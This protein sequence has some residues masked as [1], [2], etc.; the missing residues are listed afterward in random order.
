MDPSNLTSRAGE[1]PSNFHI[2]HLPTTMMISRQ[3]CTTLLNAHKHPTYL[4]VTAPKIP[5]GPTIESPHQAVLVPRSGA[6]FR[7]IK[8]VRRCANGQTTIVLPLPSHGTERDLKAAESVFLGFF[9]RKATLLRWR[10]EDGRLRCSLPECVAD[11]D[12]PVAQVHFR[13]S[14]VTTRT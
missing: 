4:S 2:A 1:R 6:A 11:L 8:I 10:K 3:R 5:I 12:A 7:A 13:G 14:C 9:G